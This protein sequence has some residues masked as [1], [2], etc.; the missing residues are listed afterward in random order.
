MVLVRSDEAQRDTGVGRLRS[1]LRALAGSGLPVVFGPGVIHLPS[2]PRHR[3]YNRIDI[4]HRRQ[5]VR[6]GVCDRRPGRP[7]RRSPPAR[8]RWCCSSLAVR[9]P[10][11]L[12]VAGGQIV[13]GFGG[14]SGPLGARACG[15][16]DGELAYLLGPA[17]GKH[18]L[19]TGGALDPGGA[20]TVTSC[21]AC[22][23]TA[24]AA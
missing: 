13:D 6:G 7:P 2:V 9:S 23:P 18:T 12:A 14:S 22:A 10:L 8:P 19:F 21:S 20:G 24:A 5:G 1:L 17:L 4:W 11:A 3:K 16:L 15:A